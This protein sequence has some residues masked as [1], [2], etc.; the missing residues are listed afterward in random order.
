MNVNLNTIPSVQ[1]RNTWL[2]TITVTMALSSL[3]TAVGTYFAAPTL[4]IVLLSISTIG[5]AHFIAIKFYLTSTDTRIRAAY[6][7]PFES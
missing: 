6:I 4:T 5:V 3:I 2:V 7:S 1:L